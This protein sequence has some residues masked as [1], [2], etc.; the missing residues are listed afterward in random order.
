MYNVKYLFDV[1]VSLPAV[2]P[3]KAGVKK[4]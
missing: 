3:A 4:L 1:L 2:I